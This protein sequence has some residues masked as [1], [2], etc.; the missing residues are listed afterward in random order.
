MKK[1]LFT[2]LLFTVPALS[3]AEVFDGGYLGGELSFNKQSFSV[4][5]KEIGYPEYHGNY[6]GSNSR[7]L[8]FGVLGGYAFNYGDNFVGIIE[9]KLSI[10]NNKVKDEEGEEIAKEN[11]RVGLH[12]LQGYQIDNILP[13]IKVGVEAGN[14]EMN[15]SNSKFNRV[16]FEN[17]NAFGFSYGFG[18]K[19]KMVNNLVAGLDYSRVT[20]KAKNE[21]EFKS[22]SIALNISYAF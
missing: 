7:S 16:S 3:Q 9:G 11:F 4:P 21:I 18:V 2:G 14:F 20:L 15:E 22:N 1:I 13:Y 8:G 6:T 12:Y 17:N 10:P 19:V 5:A